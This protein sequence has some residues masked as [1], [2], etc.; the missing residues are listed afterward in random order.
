MEAAVADLPQVRLVYRP[1]GDMRDTCREVMLEARDPDADVVAEFWLDDD[2][3]IARN[4]VTRARSDFVHGASIFEH[5]GLLNVDYQRGVVI[6]LTED[7]V[8]YIPHLARNWCA[9]QVLY[10]PPDHERCTI[11]YPHFKVWTQMPQLTF[12]DQMM[13]ARGDHSNNDSKISLAFGHSFK[14]EDEKLRDHMRKRFGFQQ[15]EF[16]AAWAALRGS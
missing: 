5:H 6:R 14:M 4:F 8:S 11:N 3:A 7:G 1:T 2:D 9:G 15:G 10:L 12:S 16:A 13:F